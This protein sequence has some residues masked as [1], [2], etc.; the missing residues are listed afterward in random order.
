MGFNASNWGEQS[1]SLFDS[2]TQQQQQPTVS[3]VQMVA[4]MPPPEPINRKKASRFTGRRNIIA[5]RF[6]VIFLLA[7]LVFLGIYRTVVPPKQV[8]EQQAVSW[9]TGAMG[10]TSFPANRAE[11]I[12]LSFM[13]T[14]LSVD[15]N[16]SEERK[17]IL[18]LFSNE[19]KVR[20]IGGIDSDSIVSGPYI[21][22]VK[23]NSPQDATFTVYARTIALGNVAFSVPVAYDS[24]TDSFAITDTPTIVPL[25]PK[26]GDVNHSGE[27]DILGSSSNIKAD[28]IQPLMKAFFTAWGK[29]DTDSLK[30]FTIPGTSNPRC[31]AGL[32]DAYTYISNEPPEVT[33]TSG[34]E[35]IARVTVTWGKNSVIGQN[36]KEDGDMNLDK[37]ITVTG[38][39][40]VKIVKKGEAYYVDDITGNSFYNS[41]F[42]EQTK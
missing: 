29:S 17:N 11:G 7:G 40:L 8:S 31:Y 42:K 26:I 41:T 1:T 37:T 34:G 9:V 3:N 23:Y 2:P 33:T 6:I 21:M 38:T 35:N 18:K 30:S 5:L 36:S 12:V 14:Y 13:Q 24:K 27:K 4:P 22:G 19:N 39:Y 25:P 16:N 28:D 15:S 32:R 20:D 10:V